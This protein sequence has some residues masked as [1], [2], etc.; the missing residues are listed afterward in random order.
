MAK[1]HGARESKEITLLNNI[2]T[3]G[4][5]NS[6]REDVSGFGDLAFRLTGATGVGG[7]ATFKVQFSDDASNWV[8]YNLLIDNVV[9][10]NT[11]NLTRV[12]VKNISTTTSVLLWTTPNTYG[13]YVRTNVE[14]KTAGTYTCVLMANAK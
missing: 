1:V 13:K 14:V 3:T 9:N 2:T 12:G 4:S 11:Q 8:D 6:D 5:T 7:N 10:A